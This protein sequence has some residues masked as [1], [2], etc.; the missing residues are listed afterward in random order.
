MSQTDISVT[1]GGNPINVSLSNFFPIT[2][3]FVNFSFTATEGQTEFT[4]DSAVRTNG[5]IIVI[6]NGTQQ[7]QAA[8]DFTVD[9]AVITMDEGLPEGAKLYGAYSI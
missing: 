3:K 7:N 2:D 5:L 1:I 6:I 8:G 9:G 4:L